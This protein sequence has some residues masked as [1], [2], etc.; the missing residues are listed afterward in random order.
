MLQHELKPRRHIPA[1]ALAVA[2]AWVGFIAAPHAQQAA[3]PPRQP[4]AEARGAAPAQPGNLTVLQRSAAPD[5]KA[6]DGKASDGKAPAGATS[7]VTVSAYLVEDGQRIDQGL[8]W[9][10]FREKAASDGKN[11]LVAQHRDAA[12][13]LKLPPGDYLVNVAF[14][15]AHLTR[16][17]TVQAGAPSAERFVLNA[18][19]LRV[20]AVANNSEPLPASAV[21]FEIYSDERDQSGNRTRI[22]GGGKPGLIVRLNSGIYQIVSTYGDA[23]AVVR[24]DVT[25][26]TG[27]LTEVTVSHAVAKVT[28]KLVVQAGGDALADTHWSLVNLRGTVVKESV[29]ALPTHLLAPG[30]YSVNAKSGGRVFRRDFNVQAGQAAQVEVVMQ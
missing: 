22:L 7:Q 24:A 16:R 3:A 4:P 11:A 23:N 15:R 25:V 29:G 2:L 5:A 12:P 10:V 17:I 1:V 13:V 8:A 6:S 27:K 21:S 28:F 9:R 30:T 18:G 20:A 19:G 26:E 14:G